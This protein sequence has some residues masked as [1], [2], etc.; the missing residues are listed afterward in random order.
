MPLCT[1]FWTVNYTD[2][3]TEWSVLTNIPLTD[4]DFLS[5]LPTVIAYAEGRI[6]RELDLM[7][8][9]IT[10]TGTLS[11]GSRR[12]TLP[13]T[14]GTFLIISDMNVITPAS[15][16]PESGTRTPLIPVS[17]AFLDLAWGSSTGST[18]P[19]Y[20]SFVTQDVTTA[21]QPKVIVGPWPDAT[22]Q[23]EVVG[24]IQPAALSASNPTTWLSINMPELLIYAGMIE[25]SGYMRNYGAG[26]ADDPQM[27]GHWQGQYDKLMA[28]AGVYQARARF[29]GASWTSKALEPM[30][31]NQ[32][33]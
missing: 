21:N 8:A 30:A 22:Y 27:P 20:Y 33:G 16:A 17:Q 2:I 5:N 6:T 24:K 23:V 28:S 11:T 10:D 13:T 25:L 19:Q 29:G 7:A 32:R 1:G 14:Y 3:T 9:N 15:T 31:Q 4:A 12:F 26:S 18:V